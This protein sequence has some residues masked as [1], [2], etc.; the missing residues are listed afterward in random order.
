MAY[1]S[2]RKRTWQTKHGPK[3]AWIADYFD[4]GGV[5]RQKTFSTRSAAKDW[6]PATQQ[7]VKARTHVPDST[8]PTVAVAAER[9]IGQ[10]E[11]DGLERSTLAQRWQHVEC[12]II[13]LIGGETKLSKVDVARFRLEL[14][15]T[16]SRALSKA[17]MTSF[18]AILKDA[19]MSH[20]AADVKPIEISGRH[21]RKLKAGVD[22]PTAAEVRALIDTG[23]AKA[24]ALVCLAAFAGLRASEIRGLRWDPDLDLDKGTVTIEMRADRW[25]YTGSPKSEAAHRTIGLNAT[26][27]RTLKE[28]KLAQPPAP[29][30]AKDGEKRHAQRGKVFGTATG[31]ADML[32]NIQRRVLNP[33]LSKAGVK[34]YSLHAFRHFA[35]SSWLKTC[36]GDFK[37]VQVRAGHQTLALTLDT[38]GHLL[39][40]NDGD[41]IAAAERLVFGSAT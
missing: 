8:A 12:H 13:P 19:K 33:L 17:V 9:W 2:V 40:A 22:F 4:Q 36:G 20:L 3:T 25:G 35:I 23:D 34:H 16:R 11:A 31:Y 18:K 39:D 21:K 1:A 28:W 15:S 10:G 6:L 30:I 29:Y 5:R 14:L 7:E 41:Q 26:T 32:G 24:R 27:V 38:Y 37:A